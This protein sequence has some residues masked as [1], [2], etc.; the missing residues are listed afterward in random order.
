MNR[1]HFMGISMGATALIMGIGVVVGSVS[2]DYAGCPSLL[3]LVL[4]ALCVQW[5]FFVPAAR[6]ENEKFYDLIGALTY[7]L[8]V[9]SGAYIALSR[10]GLST[11]QVVV[12]A[13]VCIWAVRLGAYL[14]HRVYQVGKDGRFDHIKTDPYNFFMAW[15]L[16]GLWVV[17]TTLPVVIILT[18]QKPQNQLTVWDY[19]GWSL[20]LFGF[21]IEVLADGQKS[22]FRQQAK[23]PGKWI[24]T[25]LWSWSQHPNYFGEIMLWLGLFV[26]GFSLYEGIQWIG[27]ISPIFVFVLLTRM[28][29]IPMLQ[30]RGDAK[31]GALPA[32][33]DYRT[34]TSLLI[35]W[36]RRR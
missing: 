13:M 6:F 4:L 24:D 22:K 1:A 30:E 10:G 31:W 12:T 15:T 33:R 19:I 14:A 28:S 36:P 8:V 3:G 21:V 29:G 26:S 17:L 5:L 16:Q 27:V 23:H 35:P 9:L 7:I 32:Y 2:V 34:Q 20:W 25:G 18:T 11:R